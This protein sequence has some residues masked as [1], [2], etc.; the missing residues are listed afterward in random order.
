LL[1]GS[2]AQTDQVLSRGFL[3]AVRPLVHDASLAVKKEAYWS[4]SNITAGST[5]NIGDVIQAQ[6]LRAAIHALGN[7][8]AAAA[9]SGDGSAPSGERQDVRS[10]CAWCVC[11][12]L[13]GANPAQRQVMIDSGALQ[14]S[15][16]KF[17]TEFFA[18]SCSVFSL[19]V[20]QACVAFLRES[21]G[22][23]RVSLVVVNGIDSA[24]KHLFE[25][26][27]CS[28]E[29]GSEAALQARL[30]LRAA[31]PHVRSAL[32]VLLRARSRSELYRKVVNMLRSTLSELNDVDSCDDDLEL[33]PLHPLVLD[34]Q[35]RL[36]RSWCARHSEAHRRLC[37]AQHKIAWQTQLSE[38][39]NGAE[40]A[41]SLAPLWP[42]L[43]SAVAGWLDVGSG[44][45]IDASLEAMT[46]AHGMSSRQLHI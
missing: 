8:T 1:A 6:L 2:D 27:Q 42:P 36:K 19:C 18:Y 30:C 23:Q 4:L 35:I 16:L 37:T 17:P 44:A 13:C 45:G 40:A 20:S 28:D 21:S 39:L 14:V 43:D 32:R 7:F 25:R 26:T 33:T 10:E 11:N 22:N 34:A 46:E 3:A 29:V 31:V 24:L 41:A 9:T 38:L 5:A 15:Y 12:A